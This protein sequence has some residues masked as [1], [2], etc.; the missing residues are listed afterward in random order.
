MTTHETFTPAVTVT[1]TDDR[2]V[3]VDVDWS[4]SWCS[5]L[6]PQAHE[7]HYNPHAPHA[8]VA[9]EVLDSCSDRI[10]SRITS[11]ITRAARRI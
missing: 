3:A 11:I 1:I 6:G 2:V 7:V 9:C 5:T 4:D 8:R 10:T